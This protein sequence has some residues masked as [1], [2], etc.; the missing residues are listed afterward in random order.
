LF[1]STCG[2]KRQEDKDSPGY[3]QGIGGCASCKHRVADDDA[4]KQV[5]KAAEQQP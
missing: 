1:Q 5:E 2:E 3:K 4:T